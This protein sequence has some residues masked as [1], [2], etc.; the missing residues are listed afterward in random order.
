MST[1]EIIKRFLEVCHLQSDRHSQFSSLFR[2]K[3]I[4]A[5]MKNKLRLAFNTRWI[6]VLVILVLGTV[7]YG[8][9]YFPDI[10]RLLFINSIQR[11]HLLSPAVYRLEDEKQF[12]GH[13]GHEYRL[14][15]FSKKMDSEDT[16]N[17]ERVVITDQEYHI[18]TNKVFEN[19]DV[20]QNCA[21]CWW[22]ESPVLE[23]VRRETISG[24]IIAG[25][26]WYDILQS[27]NR[28]DFV[29]HTF[30]RFEQ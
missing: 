10:K 7:I 25:A 9:S 29:K 14:F 8:Q 22:E 5:D 21:V 11:P 20:F 2:I 26:F 6:Q 24:E 27:E 1:N 4:E 3:N 16:K 18:L 23:I 13:K 15:V 12:Q 28:F 19:V 17:V 30:V